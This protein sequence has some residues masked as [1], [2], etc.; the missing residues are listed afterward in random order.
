[1]V[2]DTKYQDLREGA[3]KTTHVF[4]MQKELERCGIPQRLRQTLRGALL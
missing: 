2:R 4:W 1:M 3:M